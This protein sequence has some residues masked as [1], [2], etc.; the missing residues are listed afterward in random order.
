MRFVDKKQKLDYLFELI[1]N[2]NTGTADELCKKICVSKR[3]FVRYLQDLRDLGYQIG[4]C[5]QRKT[6]YFVEYR[7]CNARY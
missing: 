6:Y 4:F 3:T 5:T 1:D 7:R 2:D